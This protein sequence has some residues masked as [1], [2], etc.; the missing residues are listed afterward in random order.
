MMFDFPRR[1]TRVEAMDNLD[2]DDH[3]LQRALRELPRLNRLLGGYRP[4]R[5]AMRDLLRTGHGPTN[6]LDIGSGLGDLPV[7]MVKWAEAAGRPL[8]VTATDANSATVR[9]AGNYTAA[10]SNA[11]RCEVADVLDLHYADSSFDVVTASQL[12]H[13]LS[14]VEAASA[15]NQMARVAR[16]GIIISDLHRNRIAWLGIR[17]ITRVLGCG[18]MIRTD[19]PLSVRK[20]FLRA[21]L[22]AMA[23]RLQQDS[24]M[25]CRVEWHPL[26][27]WSLVATRPYS[28]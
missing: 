8:S 24:G 10:H 11:I 9:E 18:R 2:L 17:V 26:F 6:V 1:A 22:E 20:G 14:D 28:S 7:R 15:L 19:G 25:L 21:D 13:H 27:R 5:R 4:V 16:R 12:L 23:T 3:D